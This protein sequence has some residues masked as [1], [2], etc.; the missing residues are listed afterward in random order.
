M[1]NNSNQFNWPLAISKTS[2]FQNQAKCTNTHG[3]EFYLCQVHQ[4]K[5]SF[6]YQWSV[7]HLASLWNWNDFLELTSGL[8]N[9]GALS[10]LLL[11]FLHTCSTPLETTSFLFCLWQSPHPKKF[12]ALPVRS[13]GEYG[14][15]LKVIFM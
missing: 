1:L 6:S 7:V 5:K 10:L 11:T 4:N 12:L 2:W 13:I 14:D 8:L 9:V 15:F 3:N